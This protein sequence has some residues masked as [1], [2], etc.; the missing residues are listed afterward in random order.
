MSSL[1]ASIIDLLKIK[2]ELYVRIFKKETPGNFL[3]GAVS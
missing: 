1:A 3:T 2:F